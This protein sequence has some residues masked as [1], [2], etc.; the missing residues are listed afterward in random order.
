[1]AEPLSRICLNCEHWRAPDEG[2]TG[3]CRGW[4]QR[5]P[6]QRVSDQYGLSA[7]PMTDGTERCGEWVPKERFA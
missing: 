7:F 6:P 2:R 1:M 4:C 5:F 3:K